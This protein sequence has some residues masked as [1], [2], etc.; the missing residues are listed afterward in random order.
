MRGDRI[1]A[2]ALQLGNVETI[3]F[4]MG[5]PIVEA[6]TE[7]EQL[8]IRM[9][10]VRHEQAGA[11]MAHAYA[12]IRN[13]PGVCL[14]GSGPGALNFVTGV[15]N[16]FVDGAPLLVIG[17]SSQ[18]SELGMGAF[19]EVD[20][21]RAMEPFVK[22]ALR[23]HET[24]RI[25][26]M[27]QRA[28]DECMNWPPGPVY[29]DLPGDVIFGTASE[30]GSLWRRPTPRSRLSASSE[31]ILR[32]VQ[33][34]SECERPILVT[35][36]GVLWSDASQ[37]VVRF[38]EQL[39]VPVF[40]TPHGRGVVPEDH[41]MAM[42]FARSTAF[43]E[44]DLV[45][46]VGTRLNYILGYGRAPRFR[47]D[48]VFIHVDVNPNEIGRARPVDLGIVA[49]ARCALK[50]LTDAVESQNV[51]LRPGFES[52]REYLGALNMQKRSQRYAEMANDASPIHPL[53]LCGAV[54]NVMRRDD[55]LVVDGQ[56]ILNYGRQS[57]PTYT[58]R[59]R[60]NS[61]PFGTMGVGLP[62][63]IGAKAAQPRSRVF[64]LHGDGSFG[65]NCMELDTAVRHS[66][67]LVVVISN[68]GGWTADNTYKAGRDLGYT[69]YEEL[70]TALGAYGERVESAE[71]LEPALQ[72]AVG[73]G[74]PAVVNV[75]TDSRAR[76]QT[77]DF[78]GY[79]T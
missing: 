34:L 37:E 19:Q 78:T 52:W 4:L 71:Q 75:M 23:V 47:E 54:K 1:L 49:D 74:R 20:Q 3:F 56:E 55:I 22:A 27:I 65:L 70:A 67:P 13:E 6:A 32:T 69:K 11:M 46:I 24:H 31:L 63:G 29:V 16:A 62:F 2:R 26:E 30:S 73:A 21:V 53:R 17:G 7:C 64:V 39:G 45:M 58:A 51:D 25:G 50:D 44:A 9:I 5:G 8:G 76:A 43:R 35:G 61:G 77:T 12:R 28:L 60:L 59:H 14:A 41:P 66:L 33:L 38:V 36:S 18:L 40:T 68:N 57:I 10:D 72:R 79:T 42:P 48:A 15:A